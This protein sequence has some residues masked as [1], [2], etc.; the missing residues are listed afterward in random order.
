VEEKA[1][2][3]IAL[4]TAGSK[5]FFR[6]LSDSDNGS[7]DVSQALARVS[8]VL[9]RGNMEWQKSGRRIFQAKVIWFRQEDGLS[10]FYD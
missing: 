8:G 9:K 4:R 3:S 7:P 10:K 1:A 5:A 6:F 2:Y